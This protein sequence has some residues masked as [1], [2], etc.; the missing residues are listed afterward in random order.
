MKL[1][2]SLDLPSADENLELVKKVKDYD[3]WLKVGFRTYIRDGKY[4]LEEIKEINPNF[5][6]YQIQWQMQQKK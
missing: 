2:I 6:I 4:F 1:C 5:M 3:V